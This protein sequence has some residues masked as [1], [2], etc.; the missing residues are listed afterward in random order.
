MRHPTLTGL[1]VSAIRRQSAVQADGP[2][3]PNTPCSGVGVLG[4]VRENGG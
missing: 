3:V 2:L 1:L 4:Q